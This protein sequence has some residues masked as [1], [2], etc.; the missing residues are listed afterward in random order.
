MARTVTH[1]RENV[2]RQHTKAVK[3]PH[4]QPASSVPHAASHHRS[5][6]H[7]VHHAHPKSREPWFQFR[8]PNAFAWRRRTL[9]VRELPRELDGL[10]VLHVSDLH[11]R[12]YWPASYD[13]LLERIA[14]DPPDLLL[15]TGDFVEDKRDHMPAVPHVKRLVAGFQARL[16]CFGT[17]GNHDLYH[18]APHLDNTNVTLLEGARRLL[19]VGNAAIELIGLPGVHRNDYDQRFVRTLPPR[20]SRTL[21]IVMSH[22]PEHL[23]RTRGLDPDLFLTGHT[24]GGQVCL[25]GGIPLITHCNLPRALRRGLHRIGRTWHVVNHGIGYSGL[26]LRT[27]CASEV[28]ELQLRAGA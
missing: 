11:T 1:R 19:H 28:L 21:R 16:G 3:A 4:T 20:G 2:V 27:F 8:G 14:V 7:H 26:P 5:H 23:T 25:P 18:F 12:H 13:I 6:D 22:F 15:V 10:R 24:H 17:L 9:G